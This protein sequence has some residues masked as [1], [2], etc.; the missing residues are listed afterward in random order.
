M[1]IC[2]SKPKYCT[3]FLYEVDLVITTNHRNISGNLAKNVHC[4]SEKFTVNRNI[5]LRP[6]LF[7]S[8]TVEK[9][10]SVL[11]NKTL[12]IWSRCGNNTEKIIFG[13]M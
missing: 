8:L 2:A 7:L 6:S 4:Y 5:M 9:F 11:S 3:S 10:H 12:E 13:V 1:E